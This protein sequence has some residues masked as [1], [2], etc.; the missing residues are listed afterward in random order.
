MSYYALIASVSARARRREGGR[1]GE[2][3]KEEATKRAGRGKLQWVSGWSSFRARCKMQMA[4]LS[5][6]AL[7]GDRQTGRLCS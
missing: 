6:G 1:E 7:V 4:V 3:I 5:C 2:V